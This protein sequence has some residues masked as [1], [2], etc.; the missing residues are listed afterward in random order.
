MFSSRKDGSAF[1]DLLQVSPIRNASGKVGLHPFKVFPANHGA[2]DA[3]ALCNAELSS[4]YS[5]ISFV[6]RICYLIYGLLNFQMDL[7]KKL[8]DPCSFELPNRI[9]YHSDMLLLQYMQ[10]CRLT[11]AY[12]GR[13]SCVGSP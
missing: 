10:N 11:V 13:I 7:I 12:S 1:R 9:D 3:S 4:N 8:C 5:I 6:V 2:S